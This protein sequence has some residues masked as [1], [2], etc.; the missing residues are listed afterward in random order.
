MTTPEG[1]PTCGDISNYQESDEFGAVC[2]TC[3][4]PYYCAKC[5]GLLKGAPLEGWEGVFCLACGL[6]F[7]GRCLP[8]Q[9]SGDNILCERCMDDNHAA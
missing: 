9:F 5:Y 3:G 6:P 4:G 7:H 2:A 1:C 8:P